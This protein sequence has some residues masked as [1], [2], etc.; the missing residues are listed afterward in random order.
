MNNRIKILCLFFSFIF[1]FSCKSKNEKYYKH[2]GQVFGTF[3]S[4]I[5]ESNNKDLFDEIQ[6]K[7]K[8]YDYSLSNYNK[9][10]VV[11]KINTNESNHTDKYLRYMLKLSKEISKNTDGAFDITVAPLVNAWGFGFKT[12]EF[13]DSTAID[14]M[15][16]FVGFEKIQLID[17]I[18]KKD[19]SRVIIDLSAIAKGYA[20]DVIADLLEDHK[21]DNYM[22]EIGGEIR[23]KGKSSKNKNWRIGID[24][25][26][27]DKTGLNHG[28]EAIVKMNSGAMATS[29]NYRQFYY[30]DGKK[31]SHTI[32]PVSGYP[33]SHNL[34]S[35]TVVANN[36]ATADAYATAFMV[37]G[38]DKVINFLKSNKEINALLIYENNEGKLSTY[39]SEGMKNMIQK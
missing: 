5:Y 11:S 12:S 37:M 29:G 10:S 27:D 13:P 38:K 28:I 24:K 3:Y 16:T 39:I 1:F 22:I 35:T 20:C 8:E 26:F 34:L 14:S 19:D 25:P 7:F 18:V 23:C 30:K 6:E 32:D 17:S 36:C 2:R 21:I 4:I 33:V 15:K 9:E 31:Y